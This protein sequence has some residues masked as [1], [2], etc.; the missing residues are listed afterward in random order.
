M[1][2]EEAAERW[3]APLEAR[4]DRATADRGLLGRMMAY[5]LGTGGK[6]L[7]GLIPIWVCARLGGSPEA[8]LDAGAGVELLHNATLIHD[9]L[10]DGDVVRRGLP[11]VWK[12]WGAP[13]AI[14]AGDAMFF[15]GIACL[16]AAAQAADLVPRACAA[17]TRCINGQAMEFQLQS[18]TQEAEP[19]AATPSNWER[20]ARGKTGALLGL[21][22]AAGGLAAGRHGGEVDR[23]ASFGEE[24]GLLFQVQDDLLDLVGDKGREVQATDIAE[25]KLSFPVVW[26]YANASAAS[27]TE[28]RRI[29]SLAR[30]ETSP[31]EVARGLA[32]LR[33]TGAI[34]ATAGWL[35][36]AR[37]RALA[38]HEAQVVPGLVERFLAPIQHAL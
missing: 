31:A 2:L 17:V 30:D 5:H 24:L 15:D 7:R 9:D 27:A 32:I 35:R 16:A 22:F 6:R 29:V 21:C 10:Q 12:R 28:L 13:Q 26:A 14:N 38:T 23:L 19:L 34:E 18:R 3:L 8:G 25:G 4:M 1:T 11:T 33:E 20:M 36:A 37:D